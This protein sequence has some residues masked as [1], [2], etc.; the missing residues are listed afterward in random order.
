[1]PYASALSDILS[2]GNLVNEEGIQ[3]LRTR[4]QENRTTQYGHRGTAEVN[5][6]VCIGQLSR[7]AVGIEDTDKVDN[8]KHSTK[9]DE[10]GVEGSRKK[11]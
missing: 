8:S 7:Y 1:M 6:A 5:V 4:G 3:V 2:L 10:H 9:T 11:Q